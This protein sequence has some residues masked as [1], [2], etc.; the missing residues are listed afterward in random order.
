[1][2]HGVNGAVDDQLHTVLSDNRGLHVVLHHRTAFGCVLAGTHDSDKLVLHML[3]PALERTLHH[4]QSVASTPLLVFTK[5]DPAVT[6]SYKPHRKTGNHV[7]TP[8]R[9]P[10]THTHTHTHTYFHIAA[11][12]SARIVEF[13]V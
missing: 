8:A 2:K 7:G 12:L 13:V 6:R 11:A 10:H 1:M 5:E 4:V 3:S 9:E